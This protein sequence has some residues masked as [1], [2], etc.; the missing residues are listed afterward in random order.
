MTALLNLYTAN[1]PINI[2]PA[3]TFAVY[4]IIALY[5]KSGSLLAAQAFSSVAL[6][7]LLTTPVLIM[8]QV[9]PQVIQ[10]IS[11][12]DRIQ[13]YCNYSEGTTSQES[14]NSANKDD[15]SAIGLQFLTRSPSESDS[16]QQKHAI[17][18]KKQNFSWG[19]S[20]PPVLRDIELRVFK[21][22]ITMCVGA[23]G[24][25]KTTLLESILGE[26]VSTTSHSAHHV[27]RVAYCAQQPW[28][29][30][31]TIRSNIVGV[32]E[33]Q[34]RWYN[35]VISACG[36]DIDLQTLE[37]GDHTVIGSKG[38]NLSGGQKQR[39]VSLHT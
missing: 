28:L 7:N 23:V 21:G 16:D 31:G 38:L 11:I 39:I 14:I 8:I 32:S 29:E 19:K 22:G 26:T 34:Q 20:K 5:W 13:E 4:V 35:T 17:S 10:C 9:L 15:E 6:I 3:A 1:A 18:I 27:E 37:R 25:G 36:L 33:Y 24:S 30:N 12:F 2:A